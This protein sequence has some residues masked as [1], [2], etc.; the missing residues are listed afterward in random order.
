MGQR[1]SADLM[2]RGEEVIVLTRSRRPDRLCRQVLWDGVTVGPW[3]QELAGAA[4]INL[5]GEL[6]DRRPTAAA[7]DLLTRSRVEPT[8]ALVEAA[9]TLTEPPRVW[10]QMST[11]AIY[12]DGGEAVIEETS[13]VA[14][15]P[16]QMAGVARAW[17]TAASGAATHRQVILRTAVVLDRH[18]PALDR[19]ASLTR[20]GLGGRVGHGRQWVSWLHIADLLAIV[21]R[22]LDD[23]AIT[24]VVHATSPNPVRNAELMAA[25]RT[26]L[27]RPPSPP[28]PASLVRFGSMLLRTDPALALMGRRCVPAQLQAAGF[29]FEHPHLVP[30]LEDLLVRSAHG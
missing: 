20:W 17:E 27:R 3:A 16:P 30:A 11:V 9:A 22:C 4:V 24:G 19:L 13:P 18:T 8:R 10:L 26:V 23:D 28:T 15:G 1:I 5:A 6:V 14:D 2:G 7:I 25:M 12:G 29:A 21:R